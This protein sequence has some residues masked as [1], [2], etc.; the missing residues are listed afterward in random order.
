ML[1]NYL[2]IALRNIKK[3]KL[4]ALINIA[5]LSLGMTVCVLIFLWVQDEL[6]YDRFHTHAD[7]IYRV[8]FADESYDQIRHYS[9]TPPAL[10]AAMQDNFP[11]IRQAAR[12]S[13]LD[14]MVVKYGKNIFKEQIAFSDASAFD[15]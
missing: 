10:A 9:V 12:Y 7:D 15:M 8:V 5:G 13:T 11:E 14:E 3:Q 4:Y 2:K 1:K 6:S